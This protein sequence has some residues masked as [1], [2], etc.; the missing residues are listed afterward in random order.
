MRLQNKLPIALLLAA[1]LLLFLPLLLAPQSVLYS[2][3]SDMLAMHLPMK[4]FSV[5]WFQRTGELPLWCP[6][7]FSG[8][9][10]VHDVQVAAFYPLHAPLYYASPAQVGSLMSWLV[11]V[12]VILAG[13][14]MYLYGRFTGLTKTGATTAG[15]G[16]MLAGKWLLH[17]LEGGHYIFAPLAW[18][19]LVL[20]ALHTSVATR[21]SM[22]GRVAWAAC[23]GIVFGLLT[24]GAHPQITFYSGLCVALSLLL[25]PAIRFASLEGSSA[26][27]TLRQAGI[28]TGCGAAC[29][30]IAV[31]LSAIQLLPAIEATP[32]TSRSLGVDSSDALPG[33]ARALINFVGPALNANNPS[34]RWEDRGGFTVIAVLLAA[35]ACVARKDEQTRNHL[36]LAGALILFALGGAALLQWLPGFRLFRQST[37]ML[38]LAAFPVAWLAGAGVERLARANAIEDERIGWAIS[39]VLASVGILSGGLALRTWISG[40]ELLFHPYWLSLVITVPMF[41]FLLKRPWKLAPRVLAW[42]LAVLVAVDHLAL[43]VPLVRVRQPGEIYPSGAIA[44]YLAEHVKL[45]E[46]VLTRDESDESLNSPL[47]T[48]TPLALLY[49]FEAVRGYNSFDV[50]AYRDYLRRISGDP[51]ALKPFEDVW[52]FPLVGN[53]PLKDRSLVNQLGIRY[54]AQPVDAEPPPGWTSIDVIEER[55]VA[56]NLIDGGVREMKAFTLFGNPNA[57][58]RAF[59][60]SEESIHREGNQLKFDST[61]E[62][63]AAV[64]SEFTPNSVNIDVPNGLEGYLILSDA[65]YPGWHCTVGGEPTEILLANGFFRAVKI[66]AD[67]QS[68]EFRFDPSSLRYGRSISTATILLL[69][70]TACLVGFGWLMRRANPDANR[71]TPEPGETVAAS[72]V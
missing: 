68:V 9:P 71:T 47:G 44:N 54:L 33:G 30:V 63:A 7:S 41:L 16:W 26:S 72:S 1:C 69:T 55:P 3:H 40:D 34:A 21:R 4:W 20:F 31:G 70:L 50:A 32:H 52:T 48:G 66:G 2:D 60:L 37:R 36:W 25:P 58:P 8:M 14:S 24:L 28:A 65:F 53:F 19:P 49:D 38:L 10:F 43:S 35:V 45:G 6:Y 18:L 22:M 27:N 61:D 15:I 13:C 59:V 56:Y 67:D 29:V 39:R 5:S 17:V 42:T 64:I 57:L 51:N 23:G 46:R 62:V 11:V 12:H